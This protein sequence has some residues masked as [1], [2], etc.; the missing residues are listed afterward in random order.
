MDYSSS[1]DVVIVGA[2]IVG[3]ATGLALSEAHP[4]LRLAILEKEPVVANH[5][6]GHNSGVIHSGI[7]YKPGSLKAQLCVDGARQMKAFCEANDIPYDPVGKV[8]VATSEAELPRLALLH[9][10]G[11]ANGVPGVE[12]IGPQRLREIEPQA[13]G[14]AALH[15]PYTS[16]VNYRQVSAT[17]Q[18]LLE[19][20]GVAVLTSSGVKRID[21]QGDGLRVHTSQGDFMARRLINCAGLYSDKIARMMGLAVDVRIIPF[22]GEYYLLKPAS[23][24]L[25]R[26][27]I[28]PVVDPAL[29]FL[30]VHF[31]RT[32]DGHVEAGPNAVLALAREG[33]RMTTLRPGELAETM[34]FPGFWRMAA[35]W[36][37][38]GIYEYYRSFSKAEFVRALQRLVPALQPDDVVRGGAGVRAQAITPQGALMDDFA[39][40]ETPLSLHVLNAPSPAAT[41]SLAIGQYIAVRAGEVLRLTA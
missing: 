12:R 5:Q 11:V 21:P 41:A 17:M 1:Y 23:A 13:A 15:S 8:I 3:L 26:G 10:R 39:F 38:T 37:R 36:W 7:Y 31:T 27:M 34:A 4:A 18:R 14:I 28:Y 20:R 9:E 16:I 40:A 22:R 25:V 33:Y 35:R 29:P 24:H 6:T 2:G 30:G 32:L 19:Q